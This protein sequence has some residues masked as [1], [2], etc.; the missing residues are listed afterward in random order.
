MTG[1][2]RAAFTLI[3]LLVVIA[4]IAILAAILFPIFTKAKQTA[5]VNTCINNLK[6]MSVG[7]QSYTDDYSGHFPWAGADQYNRHTPG[8]P[9]FG[10]G[11]STTGWSAIKK[12]IR[13]NE[14][15]WCPLYKANYG[16]Y[17]KQWL[18]NPEAMKD[19]WSYWYYCGHN[20]PWVSGYYDSTSKSGAELCGYTLA[21]ITYP[22]RKPNICEVGSIHARGRVYGQWW[23]PTEVFTYGIA[24]VDGHAKMLNCNAKT[25]ILEAYVRRNGVKPTELSA[26]HKTIIGN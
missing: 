13:N 22:S 6:Q 16:D 21:D 3:E 20:N 10:L 17:Y 5:H 1:N 11:G 4:I 24:Y 19:A 2:K 23:N 14:V 12:Y 26:A 7:M 18:A 15:R 9:P 25:C 8:R